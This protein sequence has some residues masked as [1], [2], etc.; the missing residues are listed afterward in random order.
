MKRM[1]FLLPVVLIAGCTHQ[2]TPTAPTPSAV[3][4]SP[5]SPAAAP[6]SPGPASPPNTPPATGTTTVAAQPGQCSDGDLAVSNGE[7]ASANTL[8]HVTVSFKNT[9]SYPCTLTGYPGAD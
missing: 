8:R 7:V 9:S 1:L 3:T 2:T 5:T 4:T 6:P